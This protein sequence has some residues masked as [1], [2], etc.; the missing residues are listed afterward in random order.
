M[1]S[2]NLPFTKTE[3]YQLQCDLTYALLAATTRC[4]DKKQINAFFTRWPVSNER[5]LK[6][7]KFS[8]QGLILLAQL[9]DETP[10][11]GPDAA[12]L[13][14]LQT[15]QEQIRVRNFFL[16]NEAAILWDL[17]RESGISAIILK[18]V[19][20]YA[21][22]RSDF[23]KD[24]LVSDIDL[25]ILP[26]HRQGAVD[27]LVRHGYHE[28]PNTDP[29]FESQREANQ[30][31]YEHALAKSFGAIRAEVDLH[32]NLPIGIKKSQ[33]GRTFEMLPVKTLEH[34]WSH[35]Q[36]VRWQGK[37]FYAL[38]NEDMFVFFFATVHR[39][40]LGQINPVRWINQAKDLFELSKSLKIEKP[41]SNAKALG[42][43]AESTASALFNF[44]E[45]L[46]NERLLARKT[47]IPNLF[48][49]SLAERRTM[50]RVRAFEV[51]AALFLSRYAKNVFKILV[52][53][54]FT[55]KRPTGNK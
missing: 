11:N 36:T 21:L 8:K 27:I 22:T 12:S 26:E 33:N 47:F 23:F 42:A 52:S 10:G 39:D 43:L 9:L 29:L 19:A 49:K 4:R 34:F 16:A 15:V 24:R 18:G 30:N 35:K 40:N 38:S 53:L 20:Y 7:D 2:Q 46:F 25:L 28:L 54:L 50:S 6:C 14:F 44:S 1:T 51:W 5:W 37:S 55:D 45:T 13:T 31:S 3:K 17:L 41:A 32:W 48:Y